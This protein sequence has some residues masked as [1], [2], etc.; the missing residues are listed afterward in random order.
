[1]IGPHTRC[2][3][4]LFVVHLL[5]Y[6]SGLACLKITTFDERPGDEADSA[7]L[8]RPNYYLEEPALLRRPGKD[9]ANYLAAGAVHVER[10]VC[11]PPGLAGGL[12]AALSRFPPRV[13]VVV[14]SSRATPLLAPL[15]VVL[16]VRPPLR[17]MKASTAQ[18]ISC[19]TDLLMNVSDDTTQPTGEADRLM[20]RY[21][22][23]RPQHVWSAD[24]SRERPPAE[25]IQRLRELLG[26]CGR[27]SESS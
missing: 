23:L 1:M 24:L 16:V 20:E 12:D 7:E 14:E 10:L 27:S 15:A 26:L 22:E 18:I 4:S 11:R 8:V 2:G 6:I 21:G 5:R 19:V 25:M 13:P 3:K 17:E 9:T